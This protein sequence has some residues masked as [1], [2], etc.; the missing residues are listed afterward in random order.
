MN[1]TTFVRRDEFYK[2]HKK[3]PNCHSGVVETLLGV[4]EY[5]DRDF[6]DNMNEFR[7]KCGKK[8]KVTELVP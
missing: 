2:A 7:C 4:V 8:G 6:V 5:E 1:K 3:C